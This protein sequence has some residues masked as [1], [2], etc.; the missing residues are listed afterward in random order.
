MN[1]ADLTAEHL[2]RKV[3]INGDDWSITG[4]L[5]RVRHGA[6]EISEMSFSDPHPTVT[7]GRRWVELAV[8]PFE[9]DGAGDEEVTFL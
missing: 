1:T 4:L 8:G 6:D 3:T 2:Y 9:F 5:R 7:P